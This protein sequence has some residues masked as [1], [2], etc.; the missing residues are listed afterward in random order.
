MNFWNN[1]LYQTRYHAKWDN[2]K[3]WNVTPN[4]A[5]NWLDIASLGIGD[6]KREWVDQMAKVWLANSTFGHFVT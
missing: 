3:N 2:A 1:E 6:V 5:F 4:A